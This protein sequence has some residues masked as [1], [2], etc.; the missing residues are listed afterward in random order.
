MC[1]GCGTVHIARS[2]P[3]ESEG[4]LH[5][6]ARTLLVCCRDRS[7][8]SCPC[9]LTRYHLA[10]VSCSRSLGS[11]CVSSQERRLKASRV[12]VRKFSS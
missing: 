12:D 6:H 2:H 8:S 11:T 4:T 3:R 10:S 9:A 5:Q 1:V 7:S